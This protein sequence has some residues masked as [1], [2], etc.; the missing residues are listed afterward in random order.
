M[1]PPTRFLALISSNLGDG[2]TPLGK[3][4]SPAAL[5]SSQPQP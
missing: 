4:Q 1:P 2:G 5:A 3:Q